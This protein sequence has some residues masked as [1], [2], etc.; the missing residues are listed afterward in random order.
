MPHSREGATS[1]SS[2]HD[3]CR[4]TI[5]CA[6]GRHLS[7]VGFNNACASVIVM[8][9]LPC[10][11]DTP[12]TSALASNDAARHIPQHFQTCLF[13][14]SAR[15][16]ANLTSTT[17]PFTTLLSRV[18]ESGRG[19]G[20]K[21]HLRSVQK[22]SLTMN[23]P[24]YA[25]STLTMPI[26]YSNPDILTDDLTVLTLALPFLRQASCHRITSCTTSRRTGT[27]NTLGSRV[28]VATIEPSVQDNTSTSVLVLAYRK[29]C[30]PSSIP[31]ASAVLVT[32]GCAFSSGASVCSRAAASAS[33]NNNFQRVKMAPFC[34][35]S[36]LLKGGNSVR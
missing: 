26:R 9:A 21:H 13:Q 1:V 14:A 24:S 20:T 29:G 33:V 8:V 19:G 4:R 27:P 22:T 34:R 28:L 5:T 3:L 11:W 32:P 12:V 16:C 35:P 17:L 23:A 7:R 30:V 18:A 6:I 36:P 15:I 31:G 10:D 25:F 2:D